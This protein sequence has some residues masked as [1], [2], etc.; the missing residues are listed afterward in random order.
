[1]SWMD[2]SS[3]ATMV[4]AQEGEE[5]SR[6]LMVWSAALHL[7]VVTGVFVIAMGMRAFVEIPDETSWYWISVLVLICIWSIGLVCARHAV[8]AFLAVML[9]MVVTGT[10]VYIWDQTVLDGIAFN[11]SGLI[12]VMETIVFGGICMDQGK[13][14]V[15]LALLAPPAWAFLIG[16]FGEGTS[17]ESGEWGMLVGLTGAVIGFLHARLAEQSI[18]YRHGSDQYFSAVLTRRAEGLR[19]G[20]M[21]F[22]SERMRRSMAAQLDNT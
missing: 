19:Y 15:Y 22:F 2:L 1:M 17:I 6:K 9:G 14:A 20:L 18:I 12:L 3:T 10:A 13:R 11:G 7:L 4:A 16:Y 8:L 21:A 5:P